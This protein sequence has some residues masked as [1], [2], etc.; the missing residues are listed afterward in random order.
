MADRLTV[1]GLRDADGT[2]DF[3]LES[4]VSI[5]G[6]EALSLREQERVRI[7]TGYRGLE[8]REAVDVLDARMMVALVEILVSRAGK[9]VNTTRIWDA[10]RFI[11]ADDDEEADFD[12]QRLAFNFHIGRL[13]PGDESINGDRDQEKEDPEA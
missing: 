11:N 6:P 8:I 4:V 12:S 10:K 2:Y 13:S 3:D 5:N 7:L 9:T 1:K